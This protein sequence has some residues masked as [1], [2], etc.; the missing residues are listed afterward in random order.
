MRWILA[1]MFLL[2]PLSVNAALI[3]YQVEGVV[4]EFS[5]EGS[6]SVKV[7]FTVNTETWSWVSLGV[8]LWGRLWT[9]TDSSNRQISIWSREPEGGPTHW[10]NWTP[11]LQ[12]LDEV[13]QFQ[14][15]PEWKLHIVDEVIDAEPLGFL[16]RS[17]F[18]NQ[19]LTLST[20]ET[21]GLSGRVSK[22][23]QVG[24]TPAIVIF[25]AG[26]FFLVVHQNLFRRQVPEFTTKVAL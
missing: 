26:L 16:E 21:L 11:T 9:P 3:S 25:I 5:G 22:V 13:L 15:F 4:E 24:E 14:P 2:L 18:V 12:S 10:F 1:F 6:D 20:G 23:V 8:E 19:F 7:Q 17:F